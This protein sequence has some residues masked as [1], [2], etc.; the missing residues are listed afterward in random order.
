MKLL[1]KI[2]AVTLPQ[3]KQE[4]FTIKAGNFHGIYIFTMLIKI[5]LI[6]I[7]QTSFKLSQ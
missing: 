7:L 1:K 4:P 5:C 2:F 6:H 3:F